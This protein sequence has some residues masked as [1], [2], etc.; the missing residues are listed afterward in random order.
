MFLGASFAKH[1]G[2]FVVVGRFLTAIILN[3]TFLADESGISLCFFLHLS[4]RVLSC[5]SV[6]CLF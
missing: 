1:V 5:F 3:E 4:V 2:D 6:K